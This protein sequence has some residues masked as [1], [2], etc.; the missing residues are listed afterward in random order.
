MLRDA[1]ATARAVT[2]VVLSGPWGQDELGDVVAVA[3][4]EDGCGGRRWRPITAELARAI[5]GRHIASF[6][7]FLSLA[8]AERALLA[9]L[10][11]FPAVRAVR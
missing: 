5:N 6:N 7:L 8:P 2:G 10:Y 9:P 1:M 11:R 4:V 3:I